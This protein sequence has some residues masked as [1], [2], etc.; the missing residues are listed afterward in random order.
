MSIQQLGHAIR[1]TKFCPIS[2]D[3]GLGTSYISKNQ[4]LPATSSDSGQGT[5]YVSRT[6]IRT[7]TTS[8]SDQ[9][10]S[11]TSRFQTSPQTT[12]TATRAYHTSA[13]LKY[14]PQP[15]QTAARAHRMS[16]GQHRQHFAAT[17][18]AAV[19]AA[20]ALVA[21]SAVAAAG[22]DRRLHGAA[23]RGARVWGL[24]ARFCPALPHGY[25]SLRAHM[26]AQKKGKKKTK[27]Y[28]LQLKV[29][30]LQAYFGKTVLVLKAEP[31]SAHHRV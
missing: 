26:E 23:L 29:I 18:A 15:P 16:A 10:T 1:H 14:S 30:C 7:P 3:T 19:A 24:A 20:A 11:Y 21:P 27:D 17:A 6:K 5:S 22:S 13:T 31:I 25:S 4:T 9:G 12:L 28:T 8:D 2:P